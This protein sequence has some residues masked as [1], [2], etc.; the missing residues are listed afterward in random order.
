MISNL[1][2]L[3]KRGHFYYHDERMLKASAL[4]KSIFLT[5]I[6]LRPKMMRVSQDGLEAAFITEDDRLK[7]NEAIECRFN[8]KVDHMLMTI[9]GSGVATVSSFAG[10]VKILAFLFVLES[11][12][13]ILVQ[14]LST[15]PHNPQ[16]CPLNSNFLVPVLISYMIQ[17]LD[18]ETARSIFV[19]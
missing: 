12:S 7:E 11:F 3:Y 18:I 8:I 2:C 14:K 19:C 1:I 9:D 4:G 16:R 13:Y 17:V 5:D 15:S 6:L 10:K